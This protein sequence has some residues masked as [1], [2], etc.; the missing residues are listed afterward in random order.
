MTLT[1][2]R[3]ALIAAGVLGVAVIA[4]LIGRGSGGDNGGGGSAGE[5]IAC[6][7]AHAQEAVSHGQFSDEVFQLGAIPADK[8]L[9]DV[10]Q[11]KLVACTDL[12]HDGIKE[13]V[14]QVLC[15]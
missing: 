5:S 6:D 13:M 9:L 4:F 10:Y 2:P 1:I 7:Q 14:A 15:C 8:Q 3:W 12:T 11:P